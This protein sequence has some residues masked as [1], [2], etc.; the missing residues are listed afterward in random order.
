MAMPSDLLKDKVRKTRVG[1]K[2][3]RWVGLAKDVVRGTA[4]GEVG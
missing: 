3:L 2:V 1:Y 4:L